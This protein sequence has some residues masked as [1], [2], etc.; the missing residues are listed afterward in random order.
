[1]ESRNNIKW[2]DGD[3]KER[4]YMKQYNRNYG[5]YNKMKNINTKILLCAYFRFF[6]HLNQGF[7]ASTFLSYF[8]PCF[9]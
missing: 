7:G 8:T 3:W 2:L 4:N 5:N 9:G 1:M 6:V